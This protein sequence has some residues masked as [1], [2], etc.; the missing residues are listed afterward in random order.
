MKPSL[1]LNEKKH[2]KHC[3]NETFFLVEK[4]SCKECINNGIREDGGYAYRDLRDDEERTEIEEDGECLLGSG[5]G[6]G[7]SILVCSRCEKLHEHV[8]FTYD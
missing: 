7:C 1:F 6:E 2:C 5:H 3:Y 8:P 4:T